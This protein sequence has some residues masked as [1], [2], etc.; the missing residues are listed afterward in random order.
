V[1][2]SS[3]PARS[4][5]D[6][7]GPAQNREPG[8]CNASAGLQE[9]TPALGLL[10]QNETADWQLR[11]LSGVFIYVRDDDDGCALFVAGDQK[12]VYRARG[13]RA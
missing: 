3:K 11:H 7:G 10:A 12:A 2:F 13:P 6:V 9:I 4:P 1:R 8:G 5:R